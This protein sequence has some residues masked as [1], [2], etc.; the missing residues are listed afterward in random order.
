MTGLRDELELLAAEAPTVE[1]AERAL[2]GAR[3]RRAGAFGSALAALV[4]VALSATVLT[5]GSDR[6]TISTEV[7]DV[8]PSSGVDPLSYAYYDW[9]G[10]KWQAGKNTGGFAGKECAQWRVV[11]R[12]GQSFRMPEALSIYTEQSGENYMN[13]AAPVAITP[14]GRRIAYYS[15]KDQ[16]FAVRDLASGRIWLTPQTVSRATM[17]SGGGLLRL[18]PDGRFLGLNGVGW[19]NVVVDVESGQA[20]TIPEGWRVQRVPSG[21]T[22]VVV[23]DRR[24][25]FG[26]LA[27]GKVRPF[28]A[29]TSVTLS[30]LAPDGRT[31]AYVTG[32]KS[33]IN[34]DID[35]RP[36]DTVVT[37]DATT[38]KIL[39]EVKFR[40]APKDFM[41]QRVGAW[42]SPTEVTVTTPI[43]DPSR[44]GQEDD[45]PTLGETTYAI[46]VTTGQ[47]RK[48]AAYSY[49]AWAGD[50]VIP[51]I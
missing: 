30:E 44:P 32:G 10:Q 35:S 22:P 37:V 49:R 20:T 14:D 36:N 26:L 25:R 8:L 1:L 51:G 50:L 39:A 19:P 5:G 28:N 21:G 15:E 23:A 16:K 27:E 41:P 2:R 9:C 24:L 29:D 6:N 7:T 18:S 45:T 3:R 42:H 31:V 43:L 4:A 13:T 46:D 48:L 33:I 11:T 17:V 38:G 40:D 47:V 34:G 12:T